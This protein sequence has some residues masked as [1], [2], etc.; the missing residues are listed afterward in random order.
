MSSE[1][2]PTYI[3]LVQDIYGEPLEVRVIPTPQQIP[4][5]LIIKVLYA[6][7]ASYLG[8]VYNRKRKYMY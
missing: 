3:A 2:P 8:D 7:I 6:P 5:S 4:G 1:V